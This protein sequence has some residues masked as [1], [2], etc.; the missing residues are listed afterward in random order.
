MALIFVRHTTPQVAAG[1][2]YGRTDLALGPGFETEARAVAEALRAIAPHGP[3]LTSPLT[4]CRLLAER[5][6]PFETRAAFIEMDFGA[7]EGQPWADIPRAELDAWAADFYGARPHGGETVADLRDR[8]ADGLA[9]LEAG[10]VIVTHAGVIKAAAALR[11]H[12][13]GWD[14]KPEFGEVLSL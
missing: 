10:T 1:T 7:W 11:G 6:G 4:R 8:V 2:C 3:I 9:A 14:I 5:L 12:P 13:E